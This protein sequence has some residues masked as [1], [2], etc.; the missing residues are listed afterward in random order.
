MPLTMNAMVDLVR[1]MLKCGDVENCGDVA[2][3]AQN[4]GTSKTPS[5]KVWTSPG[6]G[7]IKM[8]GDVPITGRHPHI[9]S[10]CQRERGRGGMTG[11]A[12]L[13]S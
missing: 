7:D 9:F 1:P 10:D 4:V 13:T 12:E 2:G 8:P 6:C 11:G 5:G 3:S